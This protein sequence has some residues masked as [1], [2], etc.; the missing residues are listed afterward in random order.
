MKKNS[1]KNL[2][3]IILNF[4]G[5]YSLVLFIVLVVGGLSVCIIILYNILTQPYVDSGASGAAGSAFDQSTIDQLSKLEF[6]SKNHN[7]L[8]LPS[9]RLNPF[10]E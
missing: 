3:S 10:S 9:G 5:R 2:F 1:T 4:L 8:N 6:S 7:Y